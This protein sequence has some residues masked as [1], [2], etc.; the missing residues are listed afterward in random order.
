MHLDS[1]LCRAR[2]SFCTHRRTSAHPLSPESNMR[3]SSYTDGIALTTS[4]AARRLIRLELRAV[5]TRPDPLLQRQ[6]P[7]HGRRARQSPDL[8][9]GISPGT[10]WLCR[11]HRGR[12]R[13]VE[14]FRAQLSHSRIGGHAGQRHVLPVRALWDLLAASIPRTQQ[15]AEDCLFS[16]RNASR[17]TDCTWNSRPQPA[18][19]IGFIGKPMPNASPAGIEDLFPCVPNDVRYMMARSAYAGNAQAMFDPRR[20]FIRIRGCGPFVIPAA[21][22]TGRTA[23]CGCLARR[24]SPSARSLGQVWP[25]CGLCPRPILATSKMAP[26]QIAKARSSWSTPRALFHRKNRV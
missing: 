21:G 3:V 2:L 22:S 15:A 6:P 18:R 9:P 19:S 4:V 17:L 24:A 16:A 10:D 14:S 12:G 7:H 8:R 13:S 26:R 25:Y 23:T 1:L 20:N 11:P 5:E